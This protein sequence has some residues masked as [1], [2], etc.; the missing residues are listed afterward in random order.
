MIL[1]L[2]M[3]Q[4]NSALSPPRELGLDQPAV[5]EIVDHDVVQLLRRAA[6]LSADRGVDSDLFMQAAWAACLDQTPGLREQ[7]EDKELRKEL[8]KLRKRGLV[9]LA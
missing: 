4:P 8:K 2:G 6:Q 1:L 3:A 5:A 7:L 9:A